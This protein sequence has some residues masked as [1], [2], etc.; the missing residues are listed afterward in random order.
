M[1]IVGMLLFAVG[2]ITCLAGG[3][4]FLVVAFQESILW[5]IGCLLVPFVALIFLFMHSDKALK[6][7]LVQVVGSLPFGVGTY[8]TFQ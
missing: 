7:F 2:G 4:W 3:I 5:G 6:P 8:M 1:Q